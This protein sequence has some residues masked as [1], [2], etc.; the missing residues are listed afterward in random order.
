MVARHSDGKDENT[1]F[2]TIGFGN[3]PLSAR[4]SMTVTAYGQI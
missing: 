2:W 4:P 3:S 1:G